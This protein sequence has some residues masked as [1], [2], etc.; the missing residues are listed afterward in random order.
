MSSEPAVQAGG[1]HS[2]EL[3]TE[4]PNPFRSVVDVNSATFPAFTALLVRSD[5]PLSLL[6]ALNWRTAASMCDPGGTPR[7]NRRPIVLPCPRASVWASSVAVAWPPACDASSAGARIG[8]GA[9]SVGPATPS[10]SQ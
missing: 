10:H 8:I 7:R 3:V 1:I 4:A 6:L 2:I 5:G 9:A